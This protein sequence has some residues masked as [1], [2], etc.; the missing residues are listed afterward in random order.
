MQT[1]L[2][3]LGGWDCLVPDPAEYP[4]ADG[5]ANSFR[6]PI[7]SASGRGHV[8]ISRA[9]LNALS[10][11]NG[12][13]ELIFK[14]A[15]GEA[16]DGEVKLKRVW[17]HSGYRANYGGASDDVNAAYVIRLVDVR[18]FLNKWSSATK[19]F[20]VTNWAGGDGD[21]YYIRE[22]IKAAGTPYTWEDVAFE[23]WKACKMLGDFQGL[24]PMNL[25]PPSD[26]YYVGVNPWRAL[27]ELLG[28]IGRT[29]AY[30]PQ[31]DK[32]YVVSLSNPVP[33]Q[34]DAFANIGQQ[35]GDL[36][37]DGRP[38]SGGACVAPEKIRVYFYVKYEDYGSERDTESTQNWATS[39]QST[40]IDVSTGAEGAVPG[41]TLT[42]WDDMPA[43]KRHGNRAAFAND[44]AMS[45]KA[46]AKVQ[47]WM[48]KNSA[49]RYSRNHFI[50]NGPAIIPN[51]GI[52][53]QVIWRNFGGREGLC[54]EV[55]KFPGLPADV[56]FDSA[57]GAGMSKTGTNEAFIDDFATE[58]LAT[59]D[60]MRKTFPNYP[61]L[62]NFVTV[63]VG[64]PDAECDAM[65]N[66][67]FLKPY[68][69]SAIFGGYVVRYSP[70]NAAMET[71]EACW[72]M[73]IGERAGVDPGPRIRKN[74]VLYGRLSGKYEA[75]AGQYAG[76]RLPLY[77]VRAEESLSVLNSCTCGTNPATATEI[78]GK[79]KVDHITFDK[80]VGFKLY[81]PDNNQDGVCVGIKGCEP[82]TVLNQWS[83]AAR[84]VWTKAPVF[85][86]NVTTFGAVKF[87]QSLEGGRIRGGGSV[88]GSGDHITLPRGARQCCQPV[89]V[90]GIYGN[91]V[92]LEYG[93]AGPSGFIPLEVTRVI[94]NQ[95]FYVTSFLYVD[96]GRITGAGMRGGILAF[97]SLSFGTSCASAPCP[98]NDAPPCNPCNEYTPPPN[99]T[100]PTPI[101]Q[102]PYG[103]PPAT[104]VPIP[105][106][107][108]SL[109][110]GPSY[111][112]PGSDTE[113]ANYI[114]RDTPVPTNGNADSFYE[115]AKL[116][117]YSFSSARPLNALQ[118]PGVTRYDNILKTFDP[119]TGI[120]PLGP[121][122]FAAFRNILQGVLQKDIEENPGANPP[123]QEP[124]VYYDPATG[125]KY[126][127]ETP[128][129]AANFAL[130]R[131]LM[132]QQFNSYRVFANWDAVYAVEDRFFP[133]AEGGT[134]PT[135]LEAS[136]F[137]IF[138]EVLYHW[139]RQDLEQ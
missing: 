106:V 25:A 55:Q 98:P 19:I 119:I 126:K 18:F 60:L 43:L 127:N 89:Q 131:Q 58:N 14:S 40:F 53:K 1:S 113:T 137:V 70:E 57:G 121:I 115:S 84:P 79:C 63:T 48:L 104:P 47:A 45:T 117:R 133:T 44:G 42:I 5:K 38:F 4:L 49:D 12:P 125:L 24:G 81:Q 3:T 68:E 17:M 90:K 93:Q 23:L 76:T 99:Y 130:S 30:D 95:V 138:R 13:L 61:R 16:G 136:E 124:G 82:N 41:T 85:G 22:T 88:R 80:G 2:V 33:S 34:G 74:D 28:Q 7:G 114:R 132:Q 134:G 10:P 120:Y 9:V 123:A 105:A 86:S 66:V 59:P 135:P 65:G 102:P 96:C 107:P 15:G 37:Y 39:D 111:G 75:A 91:C 20:N 32:F 11:A 118:S 97:P 31:N 8:L 21:R 129:N 36:L 110:N 62:P 109:V 92:E 73:A 72:I 108:V 50:L 51:A 46:Q 101:S 77:V 64:K 69:G 87:G 112:L 71:L 100:P 122:D 116:V 78:Q 83:T 103:Q 128:S 56:D 29:I 54:T 94:N 35:R 26:L 27:N 52:Y 139:A 67:G 6:C